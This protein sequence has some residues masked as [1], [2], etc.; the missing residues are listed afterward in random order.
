MKS[1]KKTVLD[2]SGQNSIY[3]SVRNVYGSKDIFIAQTTYAVSKTRNLS[4]ANES[5]SIKEISIS[6]S[7]ISKTK[8]L[9]SI[10][11]RMKNRLQISVFTVFQVN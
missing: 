8:I 6:P 5:I 1:G 7:I 3:V 4:V 9:K 11:I 10:S 2:V